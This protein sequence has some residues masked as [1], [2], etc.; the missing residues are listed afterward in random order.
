[1]AGLSLAQ[2]AKRA[3]V[4]LLLALAQAY[5]L[6]VSVSRESADA[7]IQKAFRKVAR[8]VHPDKGGSAADT[9]RLNAARD[10]WS[11]AQRGRGRGRPAAPTAVAEPG[12]GLHVRLQYEA[13]LLTYQSWSTD[14]AL[15]AWERFCLFVNANL[16]P[17]SVKHWTATME[18]NASG[19]HH[20]HLML[21][22]HKAQD[23]L[24]SRFIF[25]STRPNASSHDYLGEGVCKKK[26]QQ[27]IDR[28]MFYVWANK[29]GTVRV[30]ANYEPCWTEATRTYQ[31]LGKWPEALW[32][33]RK[34]TSEQYEKYLY[35]S[36]D[37]VLARKRNLDAVRE[38]EASLAEA[39]LIEATTRRVRANAALYRPFPPAAAAQAWLALFLQ[40]RLRYPLLVVRGASHTGKTE[41]VKSLFKNALELK[42]GSLEV[43][44]EGMRGFDRD[45]HDGIILDDVRDMAFLAEHQDKLQG[46]YDTRVE[47][48][49][50]PGGTCAFRKYLFAVPI[51]V[52]VNES[53][54]NLHYLDSHDWLRHEGNRVLLHFPEVLSRSD[55]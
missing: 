27:S 22:F 38:Q 44:P 52:T 9:Q 34:V 24:T 40:D 50:T 54:R 2:R 4:T 3:L 35:L 19:S 32:K 16:S 1:M 15:P 42:V 31:V 25:E 7:D 53:T 46:K 26:L 21:Q 12:S 6:E 47:F 55:G 10:A 30:A 33:Q 29:V 36:R 45:T 41:W 48:A 20:L 28:G 11:A 39:A 13:V 8:R 17:W 49:T 43:F 14:A 5:G 23:C 18:T 37:G 51:A